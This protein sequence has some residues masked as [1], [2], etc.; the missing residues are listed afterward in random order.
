M[1]SIL[2]Y[3]ERDAGITR[4]AS[5]RLQE[6]LGIE[7][8]SSETLSLGFPRSRDANVDIQYNLT[9]FTACSKE[10]LHQNTTTWYEM[11]VV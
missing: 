11:L 6:L 5:I 1:G 9:S 3:L 2:G 8:Q 10:C 7:V 4:F